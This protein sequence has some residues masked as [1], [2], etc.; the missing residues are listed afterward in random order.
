MK[1][2]LPILLTFCT[3]AAFSQIPEDALKFSWG[4]PYGTARNQAIGGAAGSLGGDI[5]SLFINPAGLGFYKTGEVVVTPGLSML[6]NKGDF[7]G[8]SATDSKTAFNLGATGFVVGFGNGKPNGS[9]AFSIGVTRSANFNS[10]I[11]YKGQNNFSS[12]GE[13]YAAEVAGSGLSLNDVLNSNSVSLQGR[14]AVY[15]YLVDT[16]TLKGNANPDVISM[17]MWNSLKNNAP[18]LVNQENHIESS[19]G[20]TDIAIGY[21]SNSNDKLYIGGSLG[22]PIVNYKK[23]VTFRE[24]DP[25]GNANNNFD[26]SELKETYTTKGVGFNLKLGIIYKPA[27]QIRLGLALHTPTFFGLTDTYEAT[28]TTNTENY[29]PSPGSVTVNSN[30]FTN[31]VPASYKYDLVTPWRAMVSGSYVFSEVEDI[32]RQKGFI[33]ADIEYVNYKSNRYRTAEDDNDNTYYNGVNS[34]IKDYYKG[35]FNFRVGGELKFTTV[36]ARLGF[37]YYGNPYK[38]SELAANKKYATAGVGYRNKGIFV[39]LTYMMALN[40]KDVSFPYRL[41]DKANT[42]ASIAGTG[43]NIALTCGF[44]F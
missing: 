22:I 32:T 8:S 26:Y 5:S 23:Q 38:D 6:S 41:S 44:K 21:A 37:A 1:I 11:T 10:N 33:T 2:C 34:A 12:Y 29:P 39:D 13:Q 25:S 15:T 16:L 35:A 24:S 31:G 43:G 36:M 28:M 27:D 9:G 4:Q 7:R 18:F 14:M 19:G 40:N 30:L 17:P 42:F 3:T 20:T